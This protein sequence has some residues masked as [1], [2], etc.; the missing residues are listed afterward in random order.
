MNRGRGKQLIFHDKTY[1]ESFL[2]CLEQAHQ[3]FGIEIH[4]YCLM[5]N[6]YHLLVKTPR[7]NLSRAMRHINGVYTQN[8]N[9]KKKTDGTLFRG[10]YKAILI[11]SASYLLELSRYI[12]RNP[13]E[14]KKPLVNKLIDYKWSSYPAYLNKAKSP[15]WLTK[16]DVYGELSVMRP[17]SAYQRFVDRGLDEETRTFY[18]RDVWPAVRGSH[19]FIEQAHGQSLNFSNEIAKN[20]GRDEVSI[21]HIISTV[22]KYFDSKPSTITTARRGRG[23]RNY[24]RWIAMKLSQ[25]LSGQTLEVIAQHFN[26]GNYCTVSRTITRLK[27]AVKADSKLVECINSISTDLTP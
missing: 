21:K 22:A 6:H 10:R 3:R 12:H 15:V 13:A 19:K 18:N 23:E 25:D 8:Y 4:A 27:Q 2:N 5:G 9:Q 1:Y 24:P 11:D 7:G 14:L 20:R 26:V 17:V 16:D